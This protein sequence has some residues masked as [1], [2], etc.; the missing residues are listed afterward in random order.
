[1]AVINETL[2]L[3]TIL[4]FLP[5]TTPELPSS[6]AVKGRI[7]VLPPNTLVLINTSATHR[8]P[9]HWP[10]PEAP[11]YGSAPHPVSSFN[12]GYWLH[13]QPG[14]GLFLRPQ[15]GSFVPFSDGARG[16]LG[17]QFAMVELCAQLVGIFSNWSVELV[18]DETSGWEG[19]KARAEQI[20][21][22]GV[23]FDM[24]LRPMEMVPVR[25]VRREVKTRSEPV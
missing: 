22:E 13:P 3:F 19:A 10:A 24:T 11:C 25:F 6:I 4:P 18:E 23:V 14:G 9:A 2:R 5:K 16:C 21:S 15:R 12:P 7:H 20:L 1:V 8:H 17:R